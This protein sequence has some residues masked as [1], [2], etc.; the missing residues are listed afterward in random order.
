M[1]LQIDMV[2][3]ISSVLSSVIFIIADLIQLLQMA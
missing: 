1:L 3:F 2:I